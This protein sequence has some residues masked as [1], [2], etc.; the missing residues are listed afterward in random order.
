PVRWQ[1]RT[2]K[3]SQFPQ[4]VPDVGG[5]LPH[6]PRRFSDIPA[7]A[8]HV[9]D[10]AIGEYSS[11]KIDSEPVANGLFYDAHA[12]GSLARLVEVS[13]N[14]ALDLRG[15]GVRWNFVVLESIIAILPDVVDIVRD[16]ANLGM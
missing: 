16:G 14:E 4:H 11:D 6:A 9:N 5:R 2:G 10:P 1:R 7:I 12:N 3:P 8:N 15:Q 13:M